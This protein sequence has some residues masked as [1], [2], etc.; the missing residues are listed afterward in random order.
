VGAILG[1]FGLPWLAVT[2]ISPE[3]GVIGAIKTP[4]LSVIGTIRPSGYGF[5][6]GTLPGTLSEWG[7]V[8]PDSP[9]RAL[10][11]LLLNLANS[12]ALSLGFIT[13]AT[14]ALGR[15]SLF[16]WIHPVTLTIMVAVGCVLLSYRSPRRSSRHR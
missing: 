10:A 13:I 12:N 3:Q 15:P 7:V 5:Y 1:A 9:Q 4:W 2:I 6:C 14:H 11:D 8:G 16:L